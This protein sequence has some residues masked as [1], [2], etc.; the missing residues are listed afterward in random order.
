MGQGGVEEAWARLGTK[1]GTV[2]Q[3]PTPAPPHLQCSKSH[4]LDPTTQL[5]H[6]RVPSCSLA[7]GPASSACAP[8]SSL[9][10]GGGHHLA[11]LLPLSTWQPGQTLALQAE[12]PWWFLMPFRV[13]PCAFETLSVLPAWSLSTPTHPATLT[14]HRHLL[15]VFFP[16]LAVSFLDF[17]PHS[18]W[19]ELEGLPNSKPRLPTSL[20]SHSPSS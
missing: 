5:R 11:L 3:Q 9:C 15:S 2:H 10:L 20:P 12:V 6:R 4:P 19:S 1:W 16:K 14:H 17:E 18:S 7:H 8:P 13:K